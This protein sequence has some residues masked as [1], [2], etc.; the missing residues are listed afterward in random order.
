M[1]HATLDLMQTERA[2]KQIKDTFERL[3]ADAL[4]LSRI[5]A[6]LFVPSG[7]GLKRQS[8]RRG[9]SRLLRHHDGRRPGGSR[10]VAGEVEALCPGKVR[11]R[12]AQRTVLRHERHPP[13]RTRRRVALRLRRSVGLGGRHPARGQ[14]PR[15][16]GGHR[17]QDLRRDEGNGKKDLRAISQSEKLSLREHHLRDDAGIGGHLSVLSPKE[18]ECMFTQEHGTTFVMQ[19]GGKNALGI[20]TRRP[21]ARLRRLDAERRHHHLVSAPRMRL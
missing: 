11:I 20:Q 16:P 10:A 18:R 2:I 6:P 8:E 1:Y 4:N 12:A 3:L 21:L 13:R 19:I 14:N 9:A 15:I 7:S 5:S 17:P